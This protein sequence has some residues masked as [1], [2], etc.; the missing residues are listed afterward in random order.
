ML[1][2]SIAPLGGP[3]V[4]SHVILRSFA[5]LHVLHVPHDCK[6]LLQELLL[7]GSVQVVSSCCAGGCKKRPCVVNGP[8]MNAVGV[9]GASSGPL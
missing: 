8:G 1:H 4:G 2:A 5:L 3:V 9:G 7:P 6:S